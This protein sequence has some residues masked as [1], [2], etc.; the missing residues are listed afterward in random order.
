MNN[1]DKL[2]SVIITTKNEAE[3]IDNL[4]Q[5]L[6]R[7]TYKDL[8]IILIDN[9]SKDN[10]VRIAKKL[11]VKIYNF[12][13]E[14][15]AQRNFG[16]N[17][18]NGKFLFFL[19]ADMKLS[20]AVVEE[21]VKMCVSDKKIGALFVPEISVASNFWEK[22]K[23]FERSFYNE[24]GD[25]ITDAAR[26]FRRES[27]EKSG[28]YDETITG[29]EDWELTGRIKT[30]GYKT[31]RV[32]SVIHHYERINSLFSLVK[33]KF[34]YGLRSYRYLSKQDVPAISPKTIYFLRP[35]FYKHFDKIIAHPILSI[36]MFIMLT[37]ELFAGGSGYLIGKVKKL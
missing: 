24:E 28:G 33:K 31:G 2:V 34:Y 35:V 22:V 4:I 14:R 11:G 17:K 32:R 21:C 7:Q 27:F 5:S 25:N 12:G 15:S 10:T 1:S 30:F 36:G 9:N 23:A 26:F 3:V 13:P 6:K 37:M 20:Q 16:A 19:D 8:E 29:P 18:A